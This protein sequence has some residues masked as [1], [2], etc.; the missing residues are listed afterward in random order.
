MQF[1]AFS[2]A[3]KGAHCPSG[4]LFSLNASAPRTKYFRPLKSADDRLQNKF[5]SFIPPCPGAIQR[6]KKDRRLFRARK[7]AGFI[8]VKTPFPALFLIA[9][10]GFFIYNKVHG[11]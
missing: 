1:H 2:F 4:M 5:F 9:E 11:F 7:K 10:K 3:F 6:G 8:A